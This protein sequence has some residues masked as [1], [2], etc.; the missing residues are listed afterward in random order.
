MTALPSR[1]LAATRP[2]ITLLMVLNGLYAACIAALLLASVVLPLFIPGWPW[3]Q[4]GFKT[5]GSHPLLPL[6]LQSICVLG[7]AGAVLV[8]AVL[9]WLRAIVDTVRDGDPFIA[10]NARRLRAIAWCVLAGQG[11]GLAVVAIA[12]AVS[13]QAQPVDLGDG[14]SFTPWLSVLLLFVLAEVFAQ[15][16]RMR[17]EL[18]GTV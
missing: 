5:N 1:A 7:I 18:E 11:L 10:D 8:H 16:A 17:A 4:L 13:T 6:A 15:G 3:E 12:R 14:F 9:R 2:F